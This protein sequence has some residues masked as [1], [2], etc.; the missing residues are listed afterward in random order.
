MT[1]KLTTTQA[2]QK[3]N[4]SRSYILWSIR[5]GY[6]ELAELGEIRYGLKAVKFGNAYQIDPDD[7]Q[8]WLEKK[9]PSVGR[10]RLG[11]ISQQQAADMLGLSKGYISQLIKAGKLPRELTTEAVIVYALERGKHWMYEG[12]D[13]ALY[14]ISLSR[15]GLRLG[16]IGYEQDDTLV[17]DEFT[18]FDKLFGAMKEVALLTKW[19][20]VKGKT[21]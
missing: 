15:E 1:R 10:P 19:R 17:F 20:V 4:Y 11:E 12:G 5:R 13:R 3:A 2:A 21:K 18:S 7:V 16:R 6:E 14:G 8:A 9:R